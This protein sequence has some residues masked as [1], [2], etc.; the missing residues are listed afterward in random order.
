MTVDRNTLFGS[1]GVTR[2]VGVVALTLRGDVE[3]NTYVA[4]GAVPAGWSPPSVRDNTLWT[5]ALRTTLG[6]GR[7]FAPFVEVQATARRYDQPLVYGL[8]RD[9]NGAAAKVGVVA[10]VGP[11]LRGEIAAGWGFETSADASLGTISGW[12]LDGRLTWSPTRTIVVEARARTT[13]EPTTNAGSPGALAHALD[14]SVEWALRRDFSARLGSGYTLKRYER[15]PVDEETTMVSAGL[16]YR[17]D[18]T[19]QTFAEARFEHVT[20]SNA[21]AYDVGTLTAG[22]RIRR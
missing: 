13:V 14:G 11:T 5:G 2:E 6:P 4:D 20:A 8:R 1:L 17:F 9:A 21:A 15:I 22:V 12:L 7:S 3:R 16:T 19:F 18:R 10:D